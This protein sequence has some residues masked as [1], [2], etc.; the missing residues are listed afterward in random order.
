MTDDCLRVRGMS[1]IDELRF[2]GEVYRSGDIKGLRFDINESFY[3]S[4]WS[5]NGDYFLLVSKG[6]MG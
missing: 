3:V 1:I 6:V 4:R 2:I 5:I